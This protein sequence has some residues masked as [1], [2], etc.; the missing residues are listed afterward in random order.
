MAYFDNCGNQLI[1]VI[2][3]PM[4]VD[5]NSNAGMMGSHYG[6]KYWDVDIYDYI[7]KQTPINEKVITISDIGKNYQIPIFTDMNIGFDNSGNFMKQSLNVQIIVPNDKTYGQANIKMNTSNSINSNIA[8]VS[9]GYIPI[10]TTWGDCKIYVRTYGIANV[11][12]NM[13]LINYYYIVMCI[14]EINGVIQKTSDGHIDTYVFNSNID[15][16]SISSRDFGGTHYTV[17]I[18]NRKQDPS[19]DTDN[20]NG[21][22]GIGKMP[23][24]NIDIPPIYNDNLWATG[25]TTYVLTEGQMSDFTDWL[26]TDDWTQNLRKLRTDP[27]ENII[28]VGIAD[29]DIPKK[30]DALIFVGNI[31]SSTRGGLVLSNFVSVDCGTIDIAEYYGSFA[32]YAP[33]VI[34]TL[35]LP[36]VGFIQIPADEVVNNSI[37]VVYHIEV[38]SGEGICYVQLINKRDNFKYIWNTY[39]C[40]CTSSVSLSESNH[41][42]MLIAT[43]NA[44]INTG[45]QASGSLVNPLSAPGALSSIGASVGNVVTSKN[46][47]ITKGNIGNMSSIMCNKI[48]YLLIQRTNLTKP[49]SFQANNGYL[50]NYTGVIGNNKGFLKTNNYHAEFN[51]PSNFKA[52]IERLMNEGV[53]ING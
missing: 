6:Y 22:F 14:S 24:D 43:S 4:L 8:S 42:Q 41:T 44:I 7:L 48:P 33:Y 45:V 17:N 52:E 26:W 25:S 35:Y 51:A 10:G 37:H 36:K 9:V 21:G 18:E 28:S 3:E 11:D 38:A 32:D 13:E 5:K 50:A 53:F 47:T 27:M 19:S 31:T 16:P 2:G 49:S 1:T 29:F 23:H 46:P 40:I 15:V 30:S 39:S 34:T 20:K 12:E